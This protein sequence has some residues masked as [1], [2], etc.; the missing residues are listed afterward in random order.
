MRKLFVF[1]F[2]GSLAAC[3]SGTNE[4]KVDSM[5]TTAD[6]T[7]LD[8]LSYAYTATY[9]SKFEI[10]DAKNS[11]AIL[12]IW[13]D[14]D[15]GDLLKN[16]DFFAD[17]LQVNLSNGAILKGTR[18]SVLNSTQSF[19]NTFSTIASTVIAFM[20][21]RSSDKNQNWVCIWGKEISTDKKGKTDSVHLQETWRF[22]KAG[23]IDLMLQYAR[24][25]AQPKK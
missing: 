1:L 14:W 9:S 20:P 7:R 21:L 17:L 2:M 11:Q 24:V 6:S 4:S 19:R 15:N 22:N 16:K 8:T 10:G 5:S 12:H 3:N 25:A 13:K 18:D 23:K